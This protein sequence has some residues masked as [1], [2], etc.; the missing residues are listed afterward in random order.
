VPLVWRLAARELRGGLAGF[1]VFLAC[2]AL[3]VAAIAAVHSVSGS[4]LDG[5]QADA[6][7][8]LG[9][10]LAIRQ[11]YEPAGPDVLAAFGRAGRVSTSAEMRA[12][13]RAPGDGQS[14]LVELKAVDGA[15]PLVGRMELETG[16]GN[17]GRA[18]KA[19]A[20]LDAALARRDGRWGA[21]MER[22]VL[23]RL[24]L[25]VGDGILLGDLTFAVRGVLTREPD[26][27]AAS[28]FS[29]GPR[30]MVALASLDEAGL[31]QPGALIYWNHKLALAPGG[32]AVTTR[33]DM[34]S[35]FPDAGWKIRDVRDA[36]PQVARFVDRM[37]IFLTLVGLT[38]LLV[39]GVGVGNAVHAHMESRAGTIATL[40][41]LGAPARLITG[42]YLTQVMVLACV[43]T[44]AGLAVG[45]AAP[46]AAGPWLSAVLSVDLP[47]G[48][49]PLVL[50]QAAGFG[51]LTALAFSLWPLGRARMVPAAAL[52]REVVAPVPAGWPGWG[53]ALATGTAGLALAGL[54]VLTSGHR[55][56]AAAFVLVAAAALAAFRGAAWLVAFA[57]ARVRRP[58][59]PAF[60]LALA[61]LHRPGSP[62]AVVVPSLGIGLA[63]LV[64]VVLTQANMVRRVEQT[65]PR[66]APSFFFIDV[67]PAQ[68]EAFRALVLATPGV[69]GFDAVP[70]LRGRIVSVN[71]QDAEAMLKDSEQAWLLRGDRGLTYARE[72]PRGSEM[73]AGTWWPADYKG[74]P[75]VS[76][77]TDVAA[78]FAIGPGDRLGVNVLGRTIEARVANVRSAD[79]ASLNINFA[80]VFS[81]GLLEKAPLTWIATARADGPA[82][83][84]LQK[85]VPA[86]FPGIATVRVKDALDTVDVILGHIGLAVR[87]TAAITL[88]AGTL[89]LAGAVAAGHRRR[90][91]DAVVLKVL[92]ATRRDVLRV[93]LLEYGL[94][95]LVTAALA[96]VIGTA[97]SW[98]VTTRA[99][100]W[101]WVFLPGG[102][103]ITTLLC[104]AITLA[105][106][107]AGTWRALGQP[108]A[109]LLRN[110]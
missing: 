46:L 71:G 101:D 27:T 95:G 12:M 14:A 40:K 72:L 52:F 110:K 19:G 33:Q 59:D 43:G 67:Q 51:L 93:F 73:V 15:W 91:A 61:N 104:T 37:T 109:P 75:L 65:I 47:A 64:T 39:G 70:A 42:V 87:A 21:V 44:A 3:G 108:P 26:R 85:A 80:L 56:L 83:A 34:M 32:D 100:H 22:S 81:P 49:H 105:V 86:R 5:L 8:I 107:F 7:S 30:V 48:L 9:G 10:D 25:A 60:R 11:I 66:D 55:G 62:T 17:D 2:L 92:G 99:I 97:A 102:V 98:A 58:R 77:H 6:R 18:L 36:S 76:I 74:P 68:F 24:G 84:A 45:A 41:C 88:V 69:R 54:A 89:V 29:L 63:V 16:D 38:A 79:F 106:G 20:G 13:A 96:T 31:R 53:T 1:R 4:V 57:A 90:V 23:D 50:V 78:A 28:G 82:E 94:L 103:A 35:A